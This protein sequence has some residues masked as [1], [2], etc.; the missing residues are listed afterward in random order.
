M[1]FSCFSDFFPERKKHRGARKL[2]KD[3]V[4]LSPMKMHSVCY[5]KL[6]FVPR[7]RRSVLGLKDKAFNFHQWEDTS[8]IFLAHFSLAVAKAGILTDLQLLKQ[9]YALKKKTK[10]KR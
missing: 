9:L 3:N 7:N 5:R 1:K 4:L 8:E 2:G 6:W 10:K